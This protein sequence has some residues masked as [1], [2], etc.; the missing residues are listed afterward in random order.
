MSRFWK[1]TRGKITLFL[2]AVICGVG[3]LI[4]LWVV[5]QLW[6]GNYYSR[7]KAQIMKERTDYNV[8]S[9]ANELARSAVNNSDVNQICETSPEG[10]NLRYAIYNN[11]KQ[12]I[13][14]TEGMNFSQ[15]VPGYEYQYYFAT[16]TVIYKEDFY[17][18]LIDY[19]RFLED[20]EAAGNPVENPE[21]YDTDEVFQSF[22][23]LLDRTELRIIEEEGLEL[24]TFYGYLVE[25]LPET[26]VYS[27]TGR[28]I[29]VLYS[30]KYWIYPIAFIFFFG[31]VFSFIT[32][33]CVAGRTNSSD[34]VQP[35]YINNV[36]FD[37]VILLGLMIG[38]FA[39]WMIQN[40]H[41]MT[42]YQYYN[43]HVIMFGRAA[44]FVVMC[45]V[46]I[47][48]LMELAIRIKLG[49]WVHNTVCYRV[50]RFFAEV[51]TGL[52]FVGK[53]LA[54]VLG[55]T[56]VEGLI[57]LYG[58]YNDDWF[59]TIFFGI[60]EKAI[61]IPLFL[62]VVIKLR[63]LKD[64]GTEI[65]RGNL[66]YKIDTTGM[67]KDMKEYGE[68]LN[69]IAQNMNDAV[70]DK[71]KSERM[72]TELI[73]NV[74]H[75]IKTPLTSI[76]NYSDLIVKATGEDSELHEYS[77]VLNRQSRKL[78]VLVED[79]VEASKA[80]TGNI[81]ICPVKCNAA[82]FITQISGEFEDKFNSVGLTMV[83][84]IPKEDIFVMA[85]GRRMQRVFDNLMN[86]ICK[87]AQENTR[88]YLS[89]REEGDN[90]VF[91][92]KN[93]SRAP[94]NISPQELMERFVRGDASRNT[95]GN[96]LGLSIAMS[97]MELQGGELILEVDGDLFKAVITLP[98]I[99]QVINNEELP[100]TEDQ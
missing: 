36:P 55:V 52:P 88:V 100:K 4:S 37:V 7:S 26:D 60:I 9:A 68:A 69:S 87:Y 71:L 12:M 56:L 42:N 72:K 5:S 34:E 17:G 81:D 18:P 6:T 96:G 29:S 70:E 97:L 76:I 51:F 28:Y 45:S 64:A 48:I 62:S 80:Q 47:G 39:A 25:G 33:M 58:Y 44:V 98:V 14:K 93:T 15:G 22:G 53:T 83:T 3:L 2:A 94:L 41:E 73:T 82:N 78:K 49:G 89:L 1:S 46:G 21:E 27:Q 77:Q 74:S 10:T 32:L 24:Y 79:L 66:D 8:L 38:R 84:E 35:G 57:V 30:L 31:L 63:K 61:V 19:P 40:L 92:F 59:L 16:G 65:A 50:V 85:D 75:D 23:S 95:E 11:Q 90:A 13:G 86:N 91:T 67:I 99:Q 20:R 43:S 54:A